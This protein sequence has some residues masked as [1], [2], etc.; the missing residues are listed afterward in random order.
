MV[1]KTVSLKKVSALHMFYCTQSTLMHLESFIA[2]NSTRT[3]RN[4]CEK[5]DIDLIKGISLKP[6]ATG[7]RSGVED[8]GMTRKESVTSCPETSR[9]L[10]G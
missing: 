10:F 9:E 7:L 6:S 3:T 5:Y 4:S 8:G 1:L 2:V